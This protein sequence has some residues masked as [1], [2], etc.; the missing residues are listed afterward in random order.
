MNTSP[1]SQRHLP[2]GRIPCGPS[3]LLRVPASDLC[4]QHIMSWRYFEFLAGFTFLPASFPLLAFASV[5]PAI[6]PGRPAP[7]PRQ[8]NVPLGNTIPAAW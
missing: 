3:Y 2:T 4:W 1:S 7:S 5:K 8:G 6:A